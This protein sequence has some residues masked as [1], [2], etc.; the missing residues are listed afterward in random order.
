MGTKPPTA[1]E[2]VP[3]S[4]TKPGRGPIVAGVIEGDLRSCVVKLARQNPTFRRAFGEE[5]R[6]VTG[7]AKKKKKEK[8]V[9][10][11]KQVAIFMGWG[12]RFGI[13]S[14]NKPGATDA[15]KL[16]NKA[17]LLADLKD[18]G[19][20]KASPLLGDWGSIPADSMLVQDMRPED[21]FALGR[22]YGQESVVYKP[23]DGILGV[24]RLK[25]TPMVDI[26]LES[27]GD[28]T[29]RDQA[30]PT[31]FTKAR[32]LE[33]DRGYLWGDDIPWNNRTPITRA[34][35][36]RMIRRH[37]LEDVESRPPPLTAP[38]TDPQ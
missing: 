12:G 4:F 11:R 9:F 34:D 26:V 14:P 27:E 38:M 8:R 28:P 25:G 19:Y 6:A 18:L 10:P 5:I 3:G 2:P 20:R 16:E 1:T 22:K 15:Q 32:G 7:A 33:L 17:S 30:H 24:Y 31:L 35:V 13:I 23:S 29:L 21:L 37:D 36:R